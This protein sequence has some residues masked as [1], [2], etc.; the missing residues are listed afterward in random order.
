MPCRFR[1]AGRALFLIFVCFSCCAAA[2]PPST[3]EQSARSLTLAEYRQEL[4]R[5]DHDLKSLPEH[6]EGADQLLGSI[7]EQ[8][9]LQTSS[10]NFQIDNEWLRE[11]LE[12]YSSQ[13]EDRAEL[14]SEMELSI[15]AA[16]EGAKEFERPADA[17]A[18]SRLDQILQ[19]REYRNVAKSQSA[20]EQL[21][22][23]ALAWLIRVF[24]KIFRV[25][26]AHP[27]ASKIFLWS[28]IA[29]VVLALCAW[30]YLLVRRSVRDEYQYPRGDR[31][32]VPSSKH[33]QQWMR[34]ARTA[35][36]RGDW[37]DA[38]HLAY[39]SGISYLESSG[40][41]KPDRARTP[42]EYLRMLKASSGARDSL[43]AMT[44]RFE[45]IWYGQQ[46]ASSDDFQFS[47]AQLEKIGCR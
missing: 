11:R 30:I 16:I 36:E 31:L 20:V 46:S 22:D 38:V 28:L 44:R 6:P 9:Q 10:G 1:C 13:P 12:S 4:S 21:K 2:D 47:L 41:W 5:V 25:A 3:P 15:E 18:R 29:V 34:E 32:I 17:S 8:W 40:A 7:P 35:A 19:G 24:S 27:E 26:G 37:R 33:F 23:L 39:W 42:R 45:F 14:L 43:E